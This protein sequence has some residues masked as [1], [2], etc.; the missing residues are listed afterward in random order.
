M[1]GPNVG[2]LSCLLVRLPQHQR[3]LHEAAPAVE[4]KSTAKASSNTSRRQFELYSTPMLFVCAGEM[5]GLRQSNRPAGIGSSRTR[6]SVNPTRRPHSGRNT[7][8]NIG[9]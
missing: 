8:P 7:S 3:R 6:W 2:P 1:H 5:I 9:T 4:Q